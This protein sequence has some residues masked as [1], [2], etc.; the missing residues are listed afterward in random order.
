VFEFA[1]TPSFA[2]PG[3]VIGIWY[4]LACRTTFAVA[5][6]SVVTLLGR[7]E[8]D[9]VASDRGPGDG[10][11]GAEPHLMPADHALTLIRP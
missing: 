4:M 6:G 8:D 9:D 1:T 11:D 10:D 3:T 2:I 5:A 7:R